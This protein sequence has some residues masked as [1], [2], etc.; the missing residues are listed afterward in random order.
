[1]IHTRRGPIFAVLLMLA[2][3]LPGAAQSRDPIDRLIE[4]IVANE[5]DFVETMRQYRPVLETYLQEVDRDAEA[6]APIVRD[7]YMVGKLTLDDGVH[8]DPLFVS[9][10]FDHSPE[11]RKFPLFWQ[12]KSRRNY[13]IPE[14]FA[15]M[16]V[17]DATHF[18]QR[19]YQFEYVR[20]EFLGNIRTLVFDVAPRKE[21]RTG[22]FVG[23]VWVEDQQHKIVRFNGTYTLAAG[24]AG[25]PSCVGDQ[26]RQLGKSS[27]V[28]LGSRLQRPQ[29]SHLPLRMKDLFLC[30][31]GLFDHRGQPTVVGF[32]CLDVAAVL[33]RGL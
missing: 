30:R 29:R 4:R 2:V 19:T 20:R 6:D 3:T 11:K 22:R 23:R 24:E 9:E 16:I 31:L 26:F 18:T 8:Y 27:H 1:M 5:Q 7:H 12:K 33:N 21:G 15:Q 17:P 14:G 28:D 10:G 25:Q 13:F 32:Q